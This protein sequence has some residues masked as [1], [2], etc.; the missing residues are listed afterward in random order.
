[1][2]GMTA[3]GNPGLLQRISDLHPGR[4][5][6]LTS[7][8]LSYKLVA[9]YTLLTVCTI[10]FLMLIL[11][12]NQMDLIV[13][14][15]RLRARTTGMELASSLK[16]FSAGMLP[17][18]IFAVRGKNGIFK[19]LERILGPYAASSI[20]FAENGRIL[21]PPRTRQILTAD[22]VRDGFRAISYAEFSGRDYYARI[23][24]TAKQI[25]FYMPLRIRQLENAIVAFS[26]P[27][28]D[29]QAQLEL[30][31]RMALLTAVVVVL[32]HLVFLLFVLRTIIRPLRLLNNGSRAIAD[33]NY[34]VR[35]H[36]QRNDEIGE[37]GN[38]FN[39]MAG[40][41][42]KNTNRIKKMAVTD[43]LTGLFNRRHL[44]QS[45]ELE[46][47]R[48]GREGKPVGF[49]LLDIDHFKK[50]N[51]VHGH[52][53]GDHVLRLIADLLRKNTRATDILARYG[54]EEMAIIAPHA[55]IR[56]CRQI[57]EKIRKAIAGNK[58]MHSTGLFRITV[59]LGVS[60]FMPGKKSLDA[61]KLIKTA[62]NALYKA[63][64]TGRNRSVAISMR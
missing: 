14:N 44:M 12:E 50:I 17:S 28:D 52:Q 29:I 34:T 53:T 40:A 33:G 37:L 43:E 45:I 4:G 18:D 6:M 38:S 22:Q 47:K 21:H 20:V 13:D 59:S 61:T 58:F 42:Q 56:Q 24:Q 5:N 9:L 3:S 2:A 55:D 15:A 63:K 36:T 49:I 27:L 26:I 8:K 25:L 64:R 39:I 41:I 51:D 35:I 31:H 62:D 30:L 48:A 10:S 11:F 60:C 16:R 54:G 32:L 7:K 46:G 57:A 19:E 1:M 23:D